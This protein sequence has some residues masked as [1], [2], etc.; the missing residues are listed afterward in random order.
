M[1]IVG[2]GTEI[3]ECVRIGRLLQ[4]HGELFLTRVF[5]PREMRFMG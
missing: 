5:T 3:V 1:E 2:I 4:E